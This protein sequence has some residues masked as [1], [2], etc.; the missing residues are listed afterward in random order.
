MAA[1]S[2]ATSVVV[3]F[4]NA[5]LSGVFVPLSVEA[6]NVASVATFHG[7]AGAKMLEKQPL[8][9]FVHRWMAQ[10]LPRYGTLL[11]SVDSE[12]LKHAKLLFGLDR[13]LFEIIPNGIPVNS[14][15]PR[16]GPV[17]PGELTVAHVGS[18]NAGKGWRYRRGRRSGA[19]QGGPERQTDYRRGW[20]G[21]ESRE[22]PGGREPP[23][24]DVSWLCARSFD[25]CAAEGRRRRAD[26]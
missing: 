2:G 5:W 12:N 10:R 23:L 15:F 7:V 4:H 9:R 20:S 14:A 6:V 22:A 18:L 25:Q 1:R 3:H 16:R 17:R 13:A 24:P 11:T 21:R 19:L 8:R 26:D